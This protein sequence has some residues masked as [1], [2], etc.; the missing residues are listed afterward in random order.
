MLNG[1]IS[2]VNSTLYAAGA[3]LLIFFAGFIDGALV[4]IDVCKK[5]KSKTLNNYLLNK[6]MHFLYN[7]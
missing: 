7:E 2:V 5:N 1:G 6:Q 3:Q 4:D